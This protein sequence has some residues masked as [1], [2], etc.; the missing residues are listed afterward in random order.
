MPELATAWVTFAATTRGMEGDIRRAINRAGS[1][2]RINPQVDTRRMSA[3]A[4]RAGREFGDRFTN[5]AKTA[6]KALAAATIGAGLVDQAKQVLSV[7]MDW[8][9]NMNTLQ[10]VTGATAQQL[11]D[12]GAAARQLG[13]DVSLPATSAN[14]AAA[15]MTELAKG[16]FDVQQSMD[17]AKGSLQLA[18]AAQISATDA[19]TIQSQALQAFGLNAAGASKISDTLA[20][21]ANASSAE[22]T[23]VA[24]ALQQAG[25]VANQFGLS[26][27]DTAAAIAL[28][29]N[30]GIKGSDAGTL[31]KSSLL[32]L[33]D[34]GNP[35]QG[36]IEELGLTVYDAQGKFVGLSKLFDELGTASRSMTNEQYQAATGVLFGSDAMRLAGVAAKDG[37][38]SYDAMRVAIDRQGAAADVAAAKTR[39]LPGAWERVKNAVESLQLQGYDAVEGPITSA[40]DKVSG[41][42]GD[43]PG[44]A[45]A[46]WK[47]LTANPAVVK[48]WN[49]T[50]AAFATLA[51]AAKDV[52]PALV[53][54]GKSLGTALVTTHVIGWKAFV[55][56]LETAAGVLNTLEPLLSGIGGFMSD[57]TGLVTAAV[58]A[59]LLFKTVPGVM[60]RVTGAVNPALSNMARQLQT[61]RTGV[62]DFGDTYRTH[63][64][65]LRQVDPT[66]STAQQHFR[67]I[68]SA[69]SGAASGGLSMFRTAAGGVFTALGGWAGAGIL[70]VTAAIGAI[71]S[72]HADAAAKAREHRDAENE[73]RTTLDSATALVT[74]ATRETVAKRF[75]TD[76]GNGPTV[77]QRA[78]SLGLSTDALIDASTGTGDPRALDY[79][80]RVAA[81][82]GVEQG[83]RA[84]NGVGSGGVPINYD[85]IRKQVNDAGVSMNELNAA[86]LKQGDAWDTVQAKL[87]AA[88]PDPVAALNLQR[89]INLMPDAN[90]SM[91]TLAQS[92]EEQRNQLSGATQGQKDYI[93]ALNGTW[94]MTDEGIAR[95]KALGAEVV[96]VPDNKTVVVQSLTDD[97]QKKLEAL[98]YKVERMPD[99]TVK[100]TAE[101]QEAYARF[102]ALVQQINR[103]VDMPVKLRVLNRNEL[104]LPTRTADAPVEMPE[105]S[106]VRSSYANGAIVAQSSGSLALRQIIKPSDAGLYAGRGAGTIFAERETGGEAYIPL[107]AAKRKRSAAILS[108]VARLFGMQ[109]MADGGI[110]VDS[111]KQYAAQLAGGAYLRGGPPGPDGTDCSGAQAWM[112]NF[113]TGGSGRF[114]TAT[115][116][117][118]LLSRGFQQG[119]PPDGVAAY[120]IGWRNGGEGG[121]HTAGTI[122]DPDGGNVN[123]EMGGRSGGG[124]YGALAAGASEFPN[125]AWIQLAG[126]E[127]PNAPNNFGGAAVQRAQAGVTSARASVTSAQAAVDQANAA[128]SDAQGK[129]ASADKIAVLEKKRDAAEQKLTAAQERQ[130]AA[131]TR[132]T[133]VKEKAAGTAESGMDGKSFGQQLGESMFSAVLQSIG[134]DGSVFA[135]PLDWPNVK[136]AMAALN[137]GGG[138]LKGVLGGTREDTSAASSGGGA[139]TPFALPGLTDLLTLSGPQVTSPVDPATTTHGGAAGG[140]PGPLVAY[141]GPVTMGVDPRAMTDRQNA[142]MN[143][144]YR[145]FLPSVRPPG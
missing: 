2:T 136:S 121:G 131:E 29:A 128:V 104:N 9:N 141:N 1:A 119:D 26:A 92:I 12:A 46:A 24:Q 30:N 27:E 132:L 43:V 125:R 124:A 32:A 108:E 129:G 65:Y 61:A 114:G 28:L 97:A 50:A 49:D 88:S 99:G 89:L 20:N 93:E 15:A 96:A 76:D 115:E 101:D 51:G 52:W 142:D 10:A 77:V 58:G 133:E 8:T 80:R 117:Q 70:A 5:S 47:Q 4:D 112:A 144:A 16:G 33:T 111:V 39:G 56:I 54:I 123:V 126:G 57:H 36:A 83:L 67:T 91:I 6:M 63:M 81:E 78:Q 85:T 60:Q 71:A 25:T 98:K 102:T 105:G 14:D 66:L 21:A 62:T 145:T 135:N 42:L 113:I 64:Q 23:D 79:I 122:V 55:A 138:L 38:Q 72:A 100:I 45:S 44:K 17:A 143:S 82:R 41:A 37:S 127:D 120:W 106:G 95:F 19:A 84:I 74:A 116:A 139:G 13:N 130:T 22:I 18:A 73:L 40:L 35:A 68:G 53:E 7:G 118:A 31:L 75:T 103:P 59:W 86:L 34:Q 134:L 3:Q 90:E 140:A 137:Y 94:K 109:L 110:T 107:A 11:R 69:A 48:T 87:V